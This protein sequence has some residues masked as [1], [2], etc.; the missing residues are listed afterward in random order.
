MISLVHPIVGTEEKKILNEI[1][2]SR[3]LA[4]GKYVTEFEK[5]CATMVGTKYA[6]AVS[7]GTTA[8]HAALLAC[9]IGP[10]DK[11]LTT[12][13]SFIATANSI[14]FCGAK[15]VFADIDP[16]TYNL[17]PAAVEQVLKKEKNIKAVIV[18]HL[19]GT[20]ADMAAFLRL[21]KKYG[22]ILI[23]DCAQAHGATFKGKVVGSFGEA[24]AFSYYATKNAMCGE[25]GA[26]HTNSAL[27]DR[28]LRQ[29]INHGRSGQSTH[30]VLGYNFRLTNLAAGIGIVQLKRLAVWTEARRANAA[31][32]TENLR[33]LDHVVTPIEP[34]DT[35]PVYH[36][37]TIRVP[38]QLRKAFMQHLQSKG[39]GC[40]VYYPYAIHRQPLY[41][42]LGYK[43]GLC[44]QAEK[45]AQEVV[46]LPVH[47][48]LKK[49][50]LTIIV[51][52]IRSF[53]RK[54]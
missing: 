22:F 27:I 52:A 26:V 20:P 2:D 21:K 6:V 10:G 15:P 14:L 13:F 5:Q 24:N 53:G 43:A 49:N 7:S 54:A 18:V 50:D 29:I 45:A 51:E 41:V 12:P 3:I 25:G 37:Y 47:P 31:F 39:V 40:G 11:V 17:S 42:K 19:Y 46:S 4:S 48:A 8:L 1:V 36:Q 44:P 23:E 28:R 35:M 32:L 33:G 34:D 9:G 16:A 30:T 38:R